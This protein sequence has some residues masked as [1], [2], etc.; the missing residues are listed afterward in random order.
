LA[1]Y[2]MSKWLQDFAYRIGL[3]VWTFILSGFIVLVI[4]L[5]SVSYQSFRAAAAA[6]VK[7]LRYE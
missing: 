5:F 4:A 3:G 7:A 2:L 6:P 1:Y